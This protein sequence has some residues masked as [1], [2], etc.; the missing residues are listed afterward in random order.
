MDKLS[1]CEANYVPLS[2][3]TFLKRAAA[4]YGNRTSIIYEGTRFN[5]LQTYDR[6]R[7][8][9]SSLRSLN[10]PKHSVVSYF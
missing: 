7:R 3:L 10:M 6:C 2:P 1:K 8:L 5:W 9:A 4:V